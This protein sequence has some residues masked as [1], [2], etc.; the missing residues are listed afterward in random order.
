ME[1]TDAVTTG[2]EKHT[3]RTREDVS[4]RRVV[5][6]KFKEPGPGTQNLGAGEREKRI[7][8][9]VLVLVNRPPTSDW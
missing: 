9:L 4:Q 6:T 5:R 8:V 3:N 2:Q 1:V 7:K